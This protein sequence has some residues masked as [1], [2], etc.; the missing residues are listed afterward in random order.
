MKLYPKTFLFIHF[1]STIAFSQSV[2]VNKYFNS[3]A[4]NGV[5]DILELLVVQ[6]NLDIRGMIIKDFSSSMASDGGGKYEFKN[7]SL[8]QNL[9]AGT[10]I[11]LRTDSSAA[12]IDPADF[13]L[14][15]GLKKSTYFI[16]RGGIFDIAL[17]EMIMIKAAS[18]DTTGAGV[19]GSIHILAGGAAGAQFTAAPEPKL[20]A[21]G[22]SGTDRFVYANN[23]T[24]SLIDFNGTDATGNATGLTFGQG[25]NASNSAYISTLRGTPPSTKVQFTFASQTVGENAGGILINVSITNPSPSNATTVDVVITGGT[26]VFGTDYLSPSTTIPL[27]FPAGSSGGSSVSIYIVDDSEIE[28]DETIIFT[29]QNPSGGTNAGLGT[30]STFTLTI[31]DNDTPIPL[32]SIA[33]AAADIN[34]DLIPDKL[35]QVVKIRGIVIGPNYQTVNFSYYIQQEN[36]GIN[37]FRSGTTLPVLLLGDSVEVT[38]TIGQFRG[39]TQ[40]SHSIDADLIKLGTGTIPKALA[41]TIDEY[42]GNQELYESILI[43][44]NNVF[45]ASG[46]WPSFGQSSTLQIFQGTDTTDLRIDSDTDIDENPEPTWPRNIT[47]I[48]SQYTSSISVLDDGYQLL[49]RYYTDFEPATSIDD[50]NNLIPDKIILDNNYPNPFN[51]STVLSFSLPEMQRVKLSIYN[52][53]GELISIAADGIYGTGKHS[54]QFKADNLGSGLYFYKLETEKGSFI[55]KMLLMK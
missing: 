39:L 20:R 45:K 37:V 16:S 34:G 54:I 31:D 29:L 19:T 11:I 6:N 36:A 21:T 50:E 43:K 52:M 27:T 14:D 4:A 9:R 17:T 46:A 30:P 15:L 53:L 40:I 24:S 47:A 42:T 2:V 23:S 51:P 41:L 26:A 32:L 25:N 28:I 3:G 13:V 38:G 5:G 48:G 55:K 7:V 12:D 49:P 35:G 44:F 8:W 10:L 18:S 1:I 22:T 33:E